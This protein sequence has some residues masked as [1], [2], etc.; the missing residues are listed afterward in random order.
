MNTP[1]EAELG[2]GRH[3][4][5]PAAIPGRGWRDIGWRLFNRIMEDRAMLVAGGVTFYLLLAL[6]PALLAFVSLFGLFADPTRIPEQIGFLREVLPAEG[7]TLVRDQLTEL[8][9][10]QTGALG[11]GLA[12]SLAVALWTA[13]NGVKAIFE[14]MNIAYSE[15]ESRSLVRLNLIAFVFTLGGLVAATLLF[16]AIGVVPAVL[17]FLDIGEGAARL[18]RLLRW[19]VLL[20]I[21]ALVVSLFY[22][23]GP[24]RAPARWRWITTGSALATLVWLIASIAFSFYLDGFAHYNV[25][26]GSL[27]ALIGFLL[28]MWLSSLIV[29]VGAELNA[30]MELQTAEDTTQHP[31]SPLGSRGAVVADSLGDKVD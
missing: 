6:F 5:S 28:W 15:R 24:S 14:A 29:I 17:A 11:F 21:I 9:A 25:T 23:Y 12:L 8:A 20:P 2:R 13:N 4:R 7:Y 30:E 1:K 16:I 10:Q 31:E 27:G 18:L 3:A 19:L 26:Y 22:R